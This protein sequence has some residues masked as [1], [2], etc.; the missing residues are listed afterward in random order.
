MESKLIPHFHPL[1]EKLYLQLCYCA[2]YLLPD[3]R[4]WKIARFYSR[5]SPGFGR[6]ISFWKL[7]TTPLPISKGILLSSLPLACCWILE[8][9]LPHL[10]FIFPISE[11]AISLLVSTAL[12]DPAVHWLGVK[13]YCF[14]YYKAI[15]I[16][17]CMPVA[18]P[19]CP[20]NLCLVITST[21]TSRNTMEK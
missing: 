19:S 5:Q 11:N 17:Y 12:L 2:A 21:V 6:H 15:Y 20:N 9:L 16:Y 1:R 3:P 4:A 10:Y 18:L 13:Q 14:Y 8:K 7:C